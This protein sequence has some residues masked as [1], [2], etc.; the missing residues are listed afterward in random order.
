MERALEADLDRSSSGMLGFLAAEQTSPSGAAER[1]E[2]L[3]QLASAL[4]DLPEPMR[5]V[6]ILKH[7]RGQTLQ[8]IADHL[9]RTVPAVASLLRRGLEMLRQRWQSSE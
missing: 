1:N 8:E 3:L 2:E 7:C 9:G 5:D 6:V 4:A